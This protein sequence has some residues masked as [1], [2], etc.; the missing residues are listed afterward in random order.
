MAKTTHNTRSLKSEL[1]SIQ[2]KKEEY[3]QR[4]S[5]C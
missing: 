3:R 4:I 2:E 5:R 1:K